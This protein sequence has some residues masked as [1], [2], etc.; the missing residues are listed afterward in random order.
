MRARI[1][2][3]DTRSFASSALEWVRL[4]NARIR[5]DV[6]TFAARRRRLSTARNTLAQMDSK[7]TSASDSVRVMP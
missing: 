7:A 1:P 2:A 6:I 4:T 5:R 3:E